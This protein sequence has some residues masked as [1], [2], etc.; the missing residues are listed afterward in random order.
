MFDIG[1]TE[2]LV[3]AVV[4]IIVVGPKD[5]PGMLRTLGRYAGKMRRMAS[6]FRSQFDDALRESELDELR[7]TISDVGKLN[8]V[9]QI[10]DSVTESLDPL[11]EAAEAVRGDIEGAGGSPGG[12][13]SVAESSKDDGGT[14]KSASSESAAVE[15]DRT[16]KKTAASAA[17]P[18]SAVQKPEAAEPAA[19]KDD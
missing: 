10:R 19:S 16:P 3:I 1:W 13:G 4:A 17:A 5:L 8:P 2:L 14:P 9:N 15:A 18:K 12:S 11:K 6:E 7:T